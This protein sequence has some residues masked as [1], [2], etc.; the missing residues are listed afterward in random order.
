MQLCFGTAAR[1][2]EGEGGPSSRFGEQEKRKRRRRRRGVRTHTGSTH[3]LTVNSLA[4]RQNLK[5]RLLLIKS[6]SPRTDPRLEGEHLVARKYKMRLTRL[7]CLCS[8]PNGLGILWSSIPPSDGWNGAAAAFATWSGQKLSGPMSEE[9]N[10][11]AAAEEEDERRRGGAA[12]GGTTGGS[13]F[14]SPS[15]RSP[16]KSRRE[17]A[18]L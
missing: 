6:L 15:S 12:A 2:G 9:L 7:A 10:L 18:R 17:M 5:A 16:R 11:G 14:S 8:L 4:L 1:G 3:I 13:G